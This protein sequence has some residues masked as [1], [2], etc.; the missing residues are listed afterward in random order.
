[1]KH[2]HFIMQKHVEKDLYS[3]VVKISS[4][5]GPDVRAM[6]Y[7]LLPSLAIL[8]AIALPVLFEPHIRIAN[9]P[10][11][12][13]FCRSLGIGVIIKDTL[14]DCYF[15]RFRKVIITHLRP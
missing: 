14:G 15:K 10:L 12:G 11:K 3:R 1:M 13:C 8:I 5:S 9:L 7:A 2:S 4:A 6:M